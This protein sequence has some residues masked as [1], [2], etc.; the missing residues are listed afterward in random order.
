MWAWKHVDVSKKAYVGMFNLKYLQPVLI[1]L[2]V[3]SNHKYE[4]NLDNPE[5]EEAIN[6]LALTV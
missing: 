1:W 4:I 3:K 5:K 2:A 6:N